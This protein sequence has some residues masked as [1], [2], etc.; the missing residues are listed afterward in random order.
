[1]M[2]ES[3]L[4][5]NDV[6][7]VVDCCFDGFGAITKSNGGLEIYLISQIDVTTSPPGG[8]CEMILS[9]CLSCVC[10]CGVCV[11]VCVCLCVR[12]MKTSMCNISVIYTANNTKFGMWTPTGCRKHP[13]VYSEIHRRILASKVCFMLNM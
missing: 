4:K 13:N 9:V 11:C 3:G 5:E 2:P 1:M 12:P 10:V 8:G 6:V 7:V